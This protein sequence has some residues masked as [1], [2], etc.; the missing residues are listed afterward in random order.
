MDPSCVC[1]SLVAE[2]P[3]G[4]AD[5]SVG[6]LSL[7]YLLL[8]CPSVIS[9]DLKMLSCRVKTLKDSVKASKTSSL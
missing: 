5:E 2:P 4:I 1:S 8:V 6:S 9:I 3:F 7:S